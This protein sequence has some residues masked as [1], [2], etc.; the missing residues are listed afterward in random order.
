MSSMP[1]AVA[2]ETLAR[3]NGV[4]KCLIIVREKYNTVLFKAPRA[5]RFQFGF[6]SLFPNYIELHQEPEI[7]THSQRVISHSTS[8]VT[9]QLTSD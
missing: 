6:S 8:R 5:G 4:G 7:A 9:L 3:A 1:D 2:N